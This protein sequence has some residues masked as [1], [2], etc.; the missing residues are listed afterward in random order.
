MILVDNTGNWFGD[1]LGRQDPHNNQTPEVWFGLGKKKK[2][3]E[4]LSLYFHGVGLLIKQ[5][6]FHRRLSLTVCSTYL[7]PY[8]PP[9]FAPSPLAHFS[10]V[11]AFALEPGVYCRLC[12]AVLPFHGWAVTTPP[13]PLWV[14]LTR[15][16]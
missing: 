13:Q 10:I 12:N 6:A 8:P 1:H 15:G 4:S 9:S 2:H 14:S 3:K 11:R 5:S 16:H 7:P